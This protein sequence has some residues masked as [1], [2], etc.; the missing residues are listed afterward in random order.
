MPTKITILVESAGD[1]KAQEIE[2]AFREWQIDAVAKAI[3]T[4][5]TYMPAVKEAI[6]NPAV[7]QSLQQA[8][9]GLAAR[10]YGHDGGPVVVGHV[11]G[12]DDEGDDIADE[13]EARCNLADE[14]VKDLIMASR[15]GHVTLD[16]VNIVLGY[17]H[18]RGLP[19]LAAV[20]TEANIAP[21]N[22]A[23]EAAEYASPEEVQ[24]LLYLWQAIKPGAA[25]KSG[26]APTEAPAPDTSTPE[27]PAPD[28]PKPPKRP[29][30]KK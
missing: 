23:K 6:R 3:K 24:K 14:A 25:P 26:A 8:V 5:G 15:S 9:S 7:A 27:T 4:V 2:T 21:E 11:S 28:A 30:K 10:G 17:L 13:D 19:S 29:S 16:D 18:H 1:I 22:L 20:L 12:T